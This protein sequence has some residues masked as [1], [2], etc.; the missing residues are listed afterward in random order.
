ML[1][2]LLSLVPLALSMVACRSHD[3]AEG[4]YRLAATSVA[5]DGCGLVAAD[6]GLGTVTLRT[7]GNELQG[8]LDLLDFQLDG[9]FLRG[10][11]TFRVAGSGTDVAREV[12]GVACEVQLIQVVLEASTLGTGTA[13]EGPLVV[14]FDDARD[15]ACVCVLDAEVRGDWFAPP[16]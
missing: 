6:G 2:R 5:E 16:G 8:H 15:P 7:I 3:L 13:F 4:Q 14:T 1:S 11:E 12:G 9:R 10:V